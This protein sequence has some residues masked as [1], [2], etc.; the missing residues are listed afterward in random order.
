MNSLW[1]FG[2]CW[3]SY[4]PWRVERQRT[5]LK[6]IPSWSPGVLVNSDSL[7]FQRFPL[8]YHSLDN[9]PFLL[10]FKQGPDYNIWNQNEILFVFYLHMVQAVEHCM[11]CYAGSSTVLTAI[12][13]SM[14][15]KF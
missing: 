2:Q 9:L 3:T 7:T 15:L 11:V 1:C 6:D 8:T 4:L 14:R 10:A 13:D 5:I 12:V